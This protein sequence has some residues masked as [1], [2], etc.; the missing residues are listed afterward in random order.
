[1]KIM[2][3][4]ELHVRITKIKQILEFYANIMK[5]LKTQNSIKKLENQENHNIINENHENHENPMIPHEN[6]A[7]HENHRIPL[8]NH[9]NHE[10][11]R[12]PFENY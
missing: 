5:S 9:K 7:Y 4:F 8:E 11:L 1:M 2:K 12:M 10:N 6:H 3:I